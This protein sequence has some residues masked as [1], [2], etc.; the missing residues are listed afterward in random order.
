MT[1]KFKYIIHVRGVS[2][3]RVEG[4]CGTQTLHTRN[5][6]TP[7]MHDKTTLLLIG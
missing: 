5:A 6:S 4:G 3:R 1:L 2:L 7:L